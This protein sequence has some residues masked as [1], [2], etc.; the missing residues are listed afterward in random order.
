[1]CVELP[2]EYDVGVVVCDKGDEEHENWEKPKAPCWSD[3][4]KKKKLK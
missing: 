3:K 2:P 1:M 4:K